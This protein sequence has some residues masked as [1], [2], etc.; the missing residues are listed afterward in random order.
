MVLDILVDPGNIFGTKE[1]KKKKDEAKKKNKPGSQK[2]TGASP[3]DAALG[4][5][6][7]IPQC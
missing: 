5:E 7:G 4:A 2:S 1:A 3:S 6:K